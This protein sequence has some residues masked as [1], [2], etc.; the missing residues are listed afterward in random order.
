MANVE[1][2]T[3]VYARND[4]FEVAERFRG[5]QLATRDKVIEEFTTFDILEEKISETSAVS[6]WVTIEVEHCY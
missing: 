1:L 6:G 4:L 2:V 5:F 3:V